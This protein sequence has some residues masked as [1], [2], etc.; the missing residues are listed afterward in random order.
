MN[1]AL[2]IV[3]KNLPSCPGVMGKEKYANSAVTVPFIDVDGELSLLFQERARG[4][5][6]EGE[7]CFPGGRFD[8]RLDKDFRGTALRETAEELGISPDKIIIKG[9]MDTLVASMGATID[10]FVAFLDIAST[11][12][13][14]PNAAEVARMFTLP[15][16]YLSKLQPEIYHTRIEIHP[17]EKADD[18]RTSAILPAKELGLPEKYHRAWGNRKM[19]VLVYRTRE[20]IIWGITAE[21][22]H[23]L[24]GKT[25]P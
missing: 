7:I 22:L 10:P 14:K 5:P 3:L 20:G 23:D 6:Q 19:R 11:D 9:Q 24:L 18:G 16:T 13:L 15:L 12:E 8:G 4:I 25:R 1:S 17:D 21:I 2:D